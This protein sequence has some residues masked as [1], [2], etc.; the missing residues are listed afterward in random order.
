MPRRSRRNRRKFIFAAVWRL[1]ENTRRLQEYPAAEL[2]GESGENFS[3]SFP[4]SPGPHFPAVFK[5]AVPLPS[6]KYLASSGQLSCL[7]PPP[8]PLPVPSDRFRCYFRKRRFLPL[9]LFSAMSL[10]HWHE[11]LTK[12]VSPWWSQFDDFSLLFQLLGKVLTGNETIFRITIIY[13]K[14][15]WTDADKRTWI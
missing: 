7:A 10:F 14:Q 2:W 11:F 8:P 3:R 15:Q 12:L 9:R 1:V 4:T 13:W 5:L 6:Y